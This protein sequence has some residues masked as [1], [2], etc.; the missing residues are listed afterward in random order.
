MLLSEDTDLFF[1]VRVLC[2]GLGIHLWNDSAGSVYTRLSC[3]LQGKTCSIGSEQ[4]YYLLFNQGPTTTNNFCL[5]FI[6]ILPCVTGVGS[7]YSSVDLVHFCIVCHHACL[8][9]PG[10]QH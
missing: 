10:A 3:W 4:G 5:F 8:F 2:V 7:H 1:N 9:D 6:A